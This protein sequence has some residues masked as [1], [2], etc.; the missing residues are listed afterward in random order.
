MKNLSLL[1]MIGL[2]ATAFGEEPVPSP[3]A[4]PVAAASPAVRA[5][6]PASPT[7]GDSAT[8]IEA[9]A[10]LQ[11]N[12]KECGTQKGKMLSGVRSALTGRLEGVEPKTYVSIDV[13]PVI[14]GGRI[15]YK[16]TIMME[17]ANGDTSKVT[18]DGVTDPTVPLKYAFG[19][20]GS[21]YNA[22][23]IFTLAGNKP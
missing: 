7:V 18:A 23:V 15:K 8:Y 5:E 19:K 17:K 9:S 1:M 20:D 14:E 12:G 2:V 6:V 10:T 3:T 22:E 11:L 13:L 16:M 4:E 21:A